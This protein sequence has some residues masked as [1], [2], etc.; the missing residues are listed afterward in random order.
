MAEAVFNHL[1]VQEGLS[2]QFKVASAGTG[3]WHLGESAHYGTRRV[4]ADHG[5][6]CHSTA[7]RVTRAELADADYVVAM[8][9]SNAANL[10]RM[11]GGSTLDGRLHLLLDFAPGTQRQDV[12]DPYYEGNF[13]LVY[14]LV[15]DA[16]EGLL[17][18]IRQTEGI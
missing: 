16:C 6:A 14:R 8:D 7:R 11:A 12:P 5:I 17:A 2:D 4:L 10:R 1:L 13:E 15:N 9:R 3:D 18:Y